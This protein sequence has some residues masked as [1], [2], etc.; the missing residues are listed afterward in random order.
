M[1]GGTGAEVDPEFGMLLDYSG[2]GRFKN[3]PRMFIEEYVQHFYPGIAS[4]N[5][6]NDW[7]C[8]DKYLEIKHPEW[9]RG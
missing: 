4:E 8:L 5:P 3:L 6:E 2:K 9:K 1:F 7:I